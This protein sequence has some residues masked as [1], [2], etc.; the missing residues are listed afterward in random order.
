MTRRTPVRTAVV[1]AAV[2]LAGAGPAHAAGGPPPDARTAHHAVVAKPTP[3][4]IAALFDR[5]NAALATR[6]ARAVAALYAPDAVLLPTQSSEIRTTHDRIVDYFEHFLQQKP[7]GRIQERHITVLGPRSA[8]D[9]GLYQFTLTDKNGKAGK[10]DAR[11]TFVYELRGG[12]WLIVN[13]HS[14]VVP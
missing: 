14:S 3:R 7:Q 12:H 5:W 13:H 9:T 11:Y 2:L 4:R 8:I 1:A 10:T 6:N